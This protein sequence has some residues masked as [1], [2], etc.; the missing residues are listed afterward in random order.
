VQPQHEIY[1]YNDA[2]TTYHN[3]VGAMYRDDTILGLR[4]RNFW[5]FIAILSVVVCAT[6]GGSVG[7]SLAVR[8]AR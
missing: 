4:K 6:I 1:P 7:G 5:I 8:N 2:G 3:Q